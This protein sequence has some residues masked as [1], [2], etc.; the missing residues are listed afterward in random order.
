MNGWVQKAYSMWY[1]D[2][3]KVSGGSDGKSAWLSSWVQSLFELT[4]SVFLFF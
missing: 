3:S 1:Y 4:F 2:V